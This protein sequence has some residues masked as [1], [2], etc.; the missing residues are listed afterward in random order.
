MYTVCTYT[1]INTF[2]LGE[3]RGQQ[4]YFASILTGEILYSLWHNGHRILVAYISSCRCLLPKSIFLK[5][6]NFSSK[7]FLGGVGCSSNSHGG[8]FWTKRTPQ[9]LLEQQGKYPFTSFLYLRNRSQERQRGAFCRSMH[10]QDE[11]EWIQRE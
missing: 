5:Q 8:V 9:K 11:K 3:R 2:C 6:Y 4:S 1:D 7:P 10:W